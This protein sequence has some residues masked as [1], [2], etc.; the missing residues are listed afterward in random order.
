M[1]SLPS[2]PALELLDVVDADDRVIGCAP[3]GEV[4]RQGLRHRAAHILVF[5]PQGEV[6][7]QR[8]AWWKECQPGRW[9]TS[10]AGHVDAG[11]TYTRAACR[12]LEEELGIRAGDD[13]RLLCQL[14]AG[15]Q[16]GNEFVAVYEV[17]TDQTPHPDPHEIIDGRWCT[18]E[19]L[20]VWLAAEPES[21]T[22]AF[23]EI[24]KRYRQP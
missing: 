21:F 4:H 18:A 23:H 6:F 13:L 20:E 7:V 8:R 2:E 16:T 5:N 10:A 3:R 22:A 15:P 17:V 11:E 9:D 19:A 12:E 1:S 24:W 14:A